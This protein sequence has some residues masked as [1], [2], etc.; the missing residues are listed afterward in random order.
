[1]V[2]VELAEPPCWTVRELGDAEVEKSAAVLVDGVMAIVQLTHTPLVLLVKA[3]GVSLE[4]VSVRY[5]A[6]DDAPPE[7]AAAFV[8]RPP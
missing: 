1:M 6:L 4:A 3:P 7:P 5:A 8:T 2:I